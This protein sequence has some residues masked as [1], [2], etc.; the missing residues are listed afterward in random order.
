MSAL[1]FVLLLASRADPLIHEIHVLLDTISFFS[2]FSLRLIFRSGEERTSGAVD[3]GSDLERGWTGLVASKHNGGVLR[4]CFLH[5]GKTDIQSS[6]GEHG[7]AA[8][9]EVQFARF[10]CMAFFLRVALWW[11]VVAMETI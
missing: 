9:G 8:S 1:S 5:C 10:F 3:K 2:L 4:A 11:I 7:I 6:G